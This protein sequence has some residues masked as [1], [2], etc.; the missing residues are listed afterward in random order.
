MA[1]ALPD[2][3]PAT[4]HTETLWNGDESI[5]TGA[6]GLTLSVA[7]DGKTFSV[8]EASVPQPPEVWS[9]PIG[10]W[11]QR[12]HANSELRP[13]WGHVEKVEWPSDGYRIQ[14]WLMYPFDFHPRG[15]TH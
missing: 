2:P 6:Y 14:G 3:D 15:V 4:N 12:T 5:G 7:A 11:Q 9:G 8:I 13:L 10:A 1:L